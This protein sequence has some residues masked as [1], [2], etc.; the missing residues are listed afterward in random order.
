[1]RYWGGRIFGTK[2]EKVAGGL[3]KLHNL[4]SNSNDQSPSWETKNHTARQEIP[5]IYATRRSI[6]VFTRAHHWFLSWDRCIG[7]K[8]YHL[9]SLWFNPI[10]F[11]H[12]D[13]GFPICLFPSGLPT[14][15]LYSF[16]ISPIRVTCPTHL[17]LL[18]MIT[19]IIFGEACKYY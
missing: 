16:L 2:M 6:T 15:F 8:S 14:K 12:L 4:L 5:R 19:L 1:M 10:P 17:T 9:I 3:R 7:S 13:L 18:H 11:T